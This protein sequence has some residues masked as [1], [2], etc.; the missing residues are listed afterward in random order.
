MKFKNKTN[1]ENDKKIKK[2][3]I[4]KNGDQIWLI[5]KLKEDKIKKKIQFYKLY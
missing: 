4:K 1:Q 3:A 5:K 2:I